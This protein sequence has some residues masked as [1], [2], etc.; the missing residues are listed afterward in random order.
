MS[1]SG[2]LT[3]V[4]LN[5]VLLSSLKL[6]LKFEVKLKFL[7]IFRMRENFTIPCIEDYSE[8]SMSDLLVDDSALGSL[9]WS[10]RSR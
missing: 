5:I 6:L 7:I 2:L 8:F 4:S 3:I 9:I 10:Y 1:K